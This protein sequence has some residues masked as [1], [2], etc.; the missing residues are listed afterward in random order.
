MKNERQEEE[1]F[2]VCDIIRET[3]FELHKYLRSGHLEKVYENALAHRLRKK[4]IEVRQKEP[5]RVYDEDGELIGKLEADL[6]INNRLI[7]E[8]KACRL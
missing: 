1:I 7:I 3:S 5:I 4:G 2:A 8:V 6:I